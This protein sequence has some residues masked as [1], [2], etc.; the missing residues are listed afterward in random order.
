MVIDS[1]QDLEHRHEVALGKELMHGARFAF[2]LRWGA[3]RKTLFL[4]FDMGILPVENMGIRG[5][6]L[7]VQRL[8]QFCEHLVRVDEGL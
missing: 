8:V 1:R 4:E 6:V 3:H 5:P 2:L 7:L